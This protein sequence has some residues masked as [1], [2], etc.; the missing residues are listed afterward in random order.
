MACRS[1]Q[2]Q[3]TINAPRMWEWVRRCSCMT[4]TIVLFIPLIPNGF[5]SPCIDVFRSGDQEIGTWPVTAP[6]AVH[7]AAL[8]PARRPHHGAKGSQTGLAQAE[9]GSDM[10]TGAPR[11]P[12][13]ARAL[14]PKIGLPVSHHATTGNRRRIGTAPMPSACRQTGCEAEPGQ[15]TPPPRR[16]PSSTRL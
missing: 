14:S 8:Q 4:K 16:E 9:D 12:R 6:T 10:G 7:D 2:R 5:T 13:C 15:T 11:S 3:Q 1:A